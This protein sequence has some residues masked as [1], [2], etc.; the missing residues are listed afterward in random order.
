MSKIDQLVLVVEDEE[1]LRSTIVDLL[2]LEG[3]SV[4]FAA[5]G[6]EGVAI[7][8]RELPNVIIT[9]LSMPVMNGYEVIRALR[10][11]ELTSSIP[12]VVLSAKLEQADINEALA[13]GAAAFIRK[14][15]DADK[16]F[17]TVEGLINAKG[18]NLPPAP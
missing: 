7:A 11:N 2:E 18:S 9:D 17:Q 15:F 10:A 8:T 5:N 6:E 16:L 14:P 12:I 4:K 13:L 3:Y 1:T